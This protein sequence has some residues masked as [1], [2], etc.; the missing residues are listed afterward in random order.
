MREEGKKEKSLEMVVAV[1]VLGCAEGDGE[2]VRGSG[3]R[4]V[5]WLQQG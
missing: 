5:R 2:V 4:E 1:K 3:F